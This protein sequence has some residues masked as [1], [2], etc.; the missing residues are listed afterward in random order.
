MMQPYIY[1]FDSATANEAAD[2]VKSGQYE[3][4]IHFHSSKHQQGPMIQA[5]GP[6]D[7]QGNLSPQ[8]VEPKLDRLSMVVRGD[9]LPQPAQL[10]PTGQP[11]QQQQQPPPPPPPQHSLPPPNRQQ[12]QDQSRLA[13]PPPPP[14]S[15][16]QLDP[17]TQMANMMPG[18]DDNFGHTVH[19]RPETFS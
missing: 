6:P 8:K 11:H 9:E 12:Q 7:Q 15:G 14:P 5:G 13:P 18:G 10:P 3:S 1:V 19:H 17:I 4:I 16:Q 2:A